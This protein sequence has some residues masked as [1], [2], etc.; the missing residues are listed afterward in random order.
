MAKNQTK[1]D[2]KHKLKST[3]VK[4]PEKKEPGNKHP[5]VNPFTEAAN[6]KALLAVE[7]AKKTLEEQDR[8]DLVA[9]N[10]AVK[11]A[12]EKFGC[13]FVVRNRIEGN[14]TIINEIVSVKTK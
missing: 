5:K 11:E 1:Q 14:T 7:K 8:K 4:Q 12:A 2:Q 6:K 3:T 9:F 10:A 13:R